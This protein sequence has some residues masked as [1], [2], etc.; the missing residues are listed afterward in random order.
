MNPLHSR[1][2]NDDPSVYDSRHQQQTRSPSH[3]CPG[4]PLPL[5]SVLAYNLK[6][7]K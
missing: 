2:K 3:I 4:W 7:A 6:L 1:D 5:F